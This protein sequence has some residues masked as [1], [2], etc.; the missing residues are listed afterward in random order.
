MTEL[1]LTSGN[2]SG[3]EGGQRHTCEVRVMG[4]CRQGGDLPE[5]YEMYHDTHTQT[6]TQALLLNLCH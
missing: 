6:Q 3:G 2:N 1:E 5:S 4:S